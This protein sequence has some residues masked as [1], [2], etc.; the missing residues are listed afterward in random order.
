MSTEYELSEQEK[1]L[2]L[3]N[4]KN[5]ER[6]RLHPEEIVDIPE[7]DAFSEQIENELLRLQKTP[8]GRAAARYL[9]SVGY[10]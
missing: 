4:A 7:L 6:L 2:I 8:K 1:Y 3:L 10:Q 9:E 5:R